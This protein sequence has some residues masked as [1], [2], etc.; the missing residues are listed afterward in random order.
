MTG[1][2]RRAGRVSGLSLTGLGGAAVFL[3]VFY[4][5]R[6]MRSPDARE[7]IGEATAVIG[8]ALAGVPEPT[9]EE[10]E[11][12]RSRNDAFLTELRSAHRQAAGG[13]AVTR[14]PAADAPPEID[15]EAAGF[16]AP[17]VAVVP[18]AS[19]PIRSVSAPAPEPRTEDDASAATAPTPR[20][21]SLPAAAGKDPS[22]PVAD[23]GYGGRR[24]GYAPGSGAEPVYAPP[25]GPVRPPSETA[26]LEALRDAV[27]AYREERDD[28]G[29]HDAGQLVSEGFLAAE[30]VVSPSSGEP[31]PADFASRG[32]VRRGR[33]VKR[34]SGVVLL[35]S[36]AYERED[37]DRIL[38]F[39]R[40]ALG[41]A[42]SARRGAVW[43]A[44]DRITFVEDWRPIDARLQRQEGRDTETLSAD[45]LPGFPR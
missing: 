5:H 19:T 18:P 35:H 2:R 44:D 41:G 3:L 8:Q 9:P 32:P 29:P 15:D 33:W 1:M 40:T 45:P 24:G 22:K 42:A 10:A 34:F 31:L 36:F 12:T 23:R 27:R 38:A 16:T 14:G 26:M 21:T 6:A 4:A 17:A 30:A 28:F 37:P 43:T 39:T 20:S 7:K 13:A 11:R 25:A